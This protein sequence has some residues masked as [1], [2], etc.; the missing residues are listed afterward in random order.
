MIFGS[1]AFGELGLD[2]AMRVKPHD[3][4]SVIVRRER[5]TSFLSPLCEDT[6]KRQLSTSQDEIP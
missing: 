5:E 3:R 6:A 2:E 4:I 1:K